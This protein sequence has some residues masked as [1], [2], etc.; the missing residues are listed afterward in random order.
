MVVHEHN[1]H[2]YQEV[3]DHFSLTVPEYYN[4][5]FDV[6]DRIAEKPPT[7]VSQKPRS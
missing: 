4:F 1:M 2:N 7:T 6:I 5:A 3:Y